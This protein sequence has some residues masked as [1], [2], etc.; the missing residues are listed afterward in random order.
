MRKTLLSIGA[1]VCL[2]SAATVS[3]RSL[4]VTLPDDATVYYLLSET[5]APVMQFS[6]GKI[7]LKGDSYEFDGIKNFFISESDAP[8]GISEVTLS[9]PEFRFDNNTL[10]LQG[11]GDVSVYS[12]DGRKIELPVSYGKDENVV[13]IDISGLEKNAY[14]VK[15]GKTSFKFLKK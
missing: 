13:S 10:L 14:I 9:R 4:V 15:F 3:A 5:D 2:L 6:D 7:I 8:S 1:L 11:E 12:L